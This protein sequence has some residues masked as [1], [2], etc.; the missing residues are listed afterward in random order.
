MSGARRAYLD[1]SP[2]E[3]RGVV[4]LD[5]WPERLLIARE[6]D[7]TPRLGARYAARVEAVSAR[8]GLARLDL[9]QATGTLRLR[10]E[11]AVHE[12]QPLRVEVVAEP[13]R[14]KPAALRRIEALPAGERPGR[15][16]APPGVAEQLAA[17]GFA[18]PLTGDAAR[19]A[20]DEAEAQAIATVHA[21]AG[22]LNLAVEPTR[23]LTAVDV[24]L[25]EAGL[26]VSQANLQAIAQAARLLRLKAIGGLIALDLIGFPKSA[27]TLVAAAQ[28]AFAPD[29]AEV[30]VAA[31]SRFGLMEIAKPHARQPLHEQLLDPGGRPSARTCAQ[32]TVRAL[33]RQGRFDPGSRLVAP[34]APEIAALAVPLAAC[35]GPRFQVTAE[36]G[37]AWASDDILLR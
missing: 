33:Q 28:A 6:D 37:A 12:G 27:R 14:G 34:R 31:P 7:P 18:D 35:L 10:S 13:L 2:G 19:E 8:M 21:L 30:A 26:S 25:A 3:V 11:A 16:G 32:R 24:D 36:L 1:A 22:G 9:G 29:G 17:L 15:L 4:T 23:A 5:G 20:A